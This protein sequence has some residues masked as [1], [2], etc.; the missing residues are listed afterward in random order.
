MHLSYYTGCHKD[1][2][3][4]RSPEIK[5]NYINTIYVI[6]SLIYKHSTLIRNF[7]LT[8]AMSCEAQKNETL[9]LMLLFYQGEQLPGHLEN[10]Q[11]TVKMYLF[12]SVS[13][14]KAHTNCVPHFILDWNRMQLR[15]KLV[16]FAKNICTFIIKMSPCVCN[17]QRHEYW[18]T[19]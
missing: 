1:D 8:T 3:A 5:Y 18:L 7:N 6:Y 19:D 2:K 15:R 4:H 10:R 11:E 14:V 16:K 12:P 9:P 17:L 13:R